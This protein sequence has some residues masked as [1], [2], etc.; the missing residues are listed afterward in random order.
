MNTPICDFID[1]YRAAKK[2][3]LHMPGH[4]GKGAYSRDITEISGAD[5]LYSPR[6]IILDSERNAAA[7]FNA[8]RTVYSTEGSSLCIRAMVRLCVLYAKKRGKNPLIVAGANA[9]GTFLSALAFS[10]AKCEWI[11]SDSLLSCPISASEA[12]AAIEKYDP[13]ALYVT[14]PD[15][16]GNRLDIGALS[17]VCHENGVLLI[18]DNAHGAYLKFVGKEHP[19]DLGADMCCDSAHKTLPSLTG[20]AYL[21]I[22][23]AAPEEFCEWADDAM[24]VFA[25]TSPSY[26]TLYSLDKTNAFLAQNG[27]KKA[28]IVAKRV[29]KLK[30]SLQKLGFTVLCGEPFKLTVLP[31]SY[32]Y[33]GGELAAILSESGVVC[34]FY[35]PDHVVMMFSF[36]SSLADFTVT[37]N[38]FAAVVRRF[39]ITSAPPAI[40]AAKRVMTVREAM[41]LP[42][43]TVPTDRAKGRILASSSV[44]CPPAVPILI[45]GEEIDDDAV[46]AF[47][48]YGIQEVK[49]VA[50][51]DEKEKI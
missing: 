4:K 36:S 51:C 8:A 48:Y 16:L 35:D 26:L 14:S 12:K 34:E 3:R 44:S 22:S 47:K 31:K 27:A 17:Q 11:R 41:N 46:E 29:Q 6:G 5:V 32:G 25:S 49:V 18:V 42:F 1:G 50:E 15:Y 28:E 45:C 38:A 13:V 33:E 24:A 39:P 10:D 2:V 40:V 43:E 30:K 37:E 23:A 21:H 20:G 9:H 19:I 7:L